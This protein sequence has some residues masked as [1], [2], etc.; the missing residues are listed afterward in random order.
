MFSLV[1]SLSI[2]A[3]VTLPRVIDSKMVLQ[4]Q[5]QVK[6][7]G[8]SDQKEVSIVTSW[9]HQKYKVK[10]S[11][12]RW[13][14]VVQTPAGSYTPHTVTISDADS[15]LT[16]SDVLVGEVWIC[17]GQSNMEMELRGR[18][19]QPTDGSLEQIMHAGEMAQRIHFI[20]VP[21]DYSGQPRD[22]FDKGQWEQ[23]SPATAPYC[24]A[25]AWY[26]AT[27]VTRTLLVP[28]GLV[29]NSWGGSQIESWMTEDALRRVEGLDV[30]AAQS[31]KL[32]PNHRA[33]MLYNTMHYPVRGYT[34]KGFLWYQ[35]ESNV[36]N[37]P[38]YPALMREMV[39]L[40]RA[41]W[42]IAD[43]PFIY[44]Q[45]APHRYKGSEKRDAALLR[46]AQDKALALI[47]YSWMISTTDIGNEGCIHPAQKDAVGL[48]LATVA[49]SHVY[50]VKGLPA[51]GPRMKSVEY[52]DGK[53]IVTFRG[54]TL[55]TIAAPINGFEVAGADRVFHPA[56]AVVN[57][58]GTQV[59][60]SA[61]SV[62]QP[63][64]VR[65]AFRNFTPGTMLTD[66]YGIGAFPFR[67]DN[68]NES[69]QVITLPVRS[70][71]F[72][73]G[74]QMV[75][76]G[77]SGTTVRFSIADRGQVPF[78]QSCVSQDTQRAL[79]GP[80][81]EKPYFK[82]REALPIPAAYTP[83]EQGR[84]VGLDEGVY[85]HA[86]SPGFEILPN[87]DALAIYFS[88]P[89][90]KAENDTACTFI[91]A[92]LRFGAEE[93]DMPELFM[94]TI[95]ANDQS[96]LLWQD[97]KRLWFFGGGR[98]ISEYV[99]FRM[100][101]SDDNG[102]TWNYSVPQIAN[103]M[104]RVTAQPI[105]NAFRDPQGNIYMAMDGK[106]AESL[107][108]RS[109]NE[110]ITWQDMGGRTST[111]HSTIVPLDDKGT[112]LSIG[113]KNAFAD[114]WNPQNISHDWGATWEAPT[115]SPIPPLGTAQRPSMIRLRSGVLLVVGDSYMHKKKIAP[116]A[117]WKLGNDCYVGWSRDN[118]QTW[119][120]KALPIGLPH[121]ARPVNP[122]LGYTTVRQAPNGVIHILTSAN[123]PGLHYE[124]N[125]AWLYN[126]DE[127]LKGYDVADQF[128]LN[129]KYTTRY[130]DGKK[131]HEVTYKQGYKTGCERFWN[132]DGTLRWQ[133]QRNLKTHRGTW[134]H[135]WPNGRKR[136]ESEWNLRPTPRDLDQALT[137]CVAD[138]I[139]H[140]YDEQGR[141]TATYHF[142]D[143]LLQ[144]NQQEGGTG[145][146]GDM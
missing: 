111:R 143:G 63:I 50:G 146:V 131:Q 62:A 132:P 67:T 3:K 86:H 10:V 142:K 39:S 45:I 68:W 61:K 125:E 121:Q 84:L 133:W 24:S 42:G 69:A 51:E 64:A 43:M 21:K 71:G 100:A 144:D 137:G 7:W 93:W 78:V 120:F 17:S 124:F 99:P 18:S 19:G 55:N 127:R 110:G 145:L 75:A 102:A 138:G 14:T 129:G 46:E 16:L 15:K 88:T 126:E 140:H 41:D 29:I 52:K 30:T 97:G 33:T 56:K 65:Y 22:T 118:G 104:Q 109:S 8:W 106:G 123:F 54:A 141:L 28:V 83:T 81:P 5:T 35:G 122:S 13:Q 105:S 70:S 96:A 76:Q 114:G 44:V 101:T 87:G 31:D 91:Q 40:W 57:K 36:F 107:L 80:D 92:R 94:N 9:N 6:L 95:G 112:L 37:A 26:F 79:Q 108:W 117:G 20:T 77:D 73:A 11:D 134:T 47:P 115:A 38:L 98:G 72:K 103:P 27:H 135:Y 58:K 119:Q 53:A 23:A 113:G 66:V 2:G 136:I 49:L 32:K 85:A 34:A 59:E 82:V 48:R 74:Q 128:L 130:T 25:A 139:T 90:G 89:K 1:L 12:G 60:L 116:P 4:Q